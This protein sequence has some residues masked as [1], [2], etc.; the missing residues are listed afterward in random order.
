MTRTIPGRPDKSPG[1][2]APP[3]WLA[4]AAEAEVVLVIR[5]VLVGPDVCC[6]DAVVIPVRVVIPLDVEEVVVV[7]PGVVEV[8]VEVVAVVVPL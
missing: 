7:L 3:N 5:F 6:N 2:C 8:G 1:F 4:D